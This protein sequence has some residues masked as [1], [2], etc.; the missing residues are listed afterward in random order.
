MTKKEQLKIK[1]LEAENK[2]L[3]EK[4]DKHFSVYRDQ[5]YELVELRSKLEIVQVIIDQEVE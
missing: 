1:M 3:R 2:L 5:L 4:L